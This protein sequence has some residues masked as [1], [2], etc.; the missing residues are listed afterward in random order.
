MNNIDKNLQFK[1]TN[2]QDSTINYLDLTIY[3]RDKNLDLNIYRKP[4]NTGTCIHQLSNHPNEHKPAA[5]RYYIY[6]MQTLPFS[7]EAKHKE[8]NTILNIGKNNGYPKHW[9]NNIREKMANRRHSK[10]PKIPDNKKW[11]T[12]KY[13]SPAIR[14]ILKPI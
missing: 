10:E 6:R 9:L 3:R 13:F 12:F 14:R 8:W 1:P 11:V 4:T 7:D 5:F 2:E